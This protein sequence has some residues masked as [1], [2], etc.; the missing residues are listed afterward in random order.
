VTKKPTKLD[1][2]FDFGFT[3]TDIQDVDEVKEAIVGTAMAADEWKNKAE[4]TNEELSKMIK[5]AQKWETTAEKL[6]DAIE[7]LLDNFIKDKKDYIHW[8][9]EVRKEKI[10]Q[11]KAKLMEI[12]NG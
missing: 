1:D 4:E 2:S 3:L 11:F 10:E 6:Y 12:L 8:P 5:I 7:P 9:Y